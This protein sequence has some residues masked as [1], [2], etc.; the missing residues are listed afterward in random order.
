MGECKF[1]EFSQISNT[2]K[3]NIF[4]VQSVSL[5]ILGEKHGFTQI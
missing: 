2:F 4:T 1:P 3:K 5:E